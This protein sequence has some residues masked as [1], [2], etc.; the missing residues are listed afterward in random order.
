MCNNP[1]KLKNAACCSRCFQTSFTE[2]KINRH[3]YFAMAGL[4]VKVF[5]DIAGN[6]Q[7]GIRTQ[8]PRFQGMPASISRRARV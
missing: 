4:K 8:N 1:P 6:H 3:K 2:A 7:A 5:F